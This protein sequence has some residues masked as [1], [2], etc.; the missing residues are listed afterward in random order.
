M[1]TSSHHRIIVSSC[2][3]REFAHAERPPGALLAIGEKHID[4]LPRAEVERRA[5]R[6]HRDREGEGQVVT[7]VL[8]VRD[9]ALPKH[10]GV[11]WTWRVRV[12]VVWRVTGLASSPRGTTRNDT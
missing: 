9:C 3:L 12:D 4:P 7:R 2:H 11:T 10:A 1:L 8:V 6:F 5:V